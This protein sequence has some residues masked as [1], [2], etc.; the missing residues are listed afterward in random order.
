MNI[1][2]ISPESDYRTTALEGQVDIDPLD[3]TQLKKAVPQV[4]AVL[5]HNLEIGGMIKVANLK[6]KGRLDDLSLDGRIE[7]TQGDVR[8]GNSFHKPARIPLTLESAVRY[9]GDKIVIQKAALKLHTLVLHSKGEIGLGNS[10]AI[11]LSLDSEPASLEG[12]DK[13]IPA[14]ADRHTKGKLNL[15]ATLRGPVGSGK[16]PEVHGK[17]SFQNAG[18]QVS[19]LPKPIENLNGV[20]NLS[21]QRAE[22]QE[23]NFH[24]GSSRIQLA[25]SV[26]RL[27]PL[28]LSYRLNSQQLAVA[29][30]QRS[31]PEHRSADVLRNLNSDGQLTIVKGQTTVT[32]K[33]GSSDGR[34][35]GLDYKNLDANLAYANNA[36]ALRDLRFNA[37]S[38]SLRLTGAYSSAEIPKF[39]AASEIKAVDLGQLS[40]YFNQEQSDVR[41]KLNGNLKLSGAGDEWQNIK[42]TL[43]GDGRGE[44][45]QG[46][47]LNFNLADAVLSGTS[48]IP[49]LTNLINPAVRRKYPETFE[50]KDT[51]FKDLQTQFDVGDSRINFKNLIIAAAQFKVEGNGWADF[52]RRVDFRAVVRFSPE[53]SSDIA[54]SVR[55]IRFLFNRNNELEIPFTLAGQMP[56]VRPQPDARFLTKSLQRGLV[57][58]GVDELQQQLFGTKERNSADGRQKDEHR[59]PQSSPEDL[60]RRGLEGLFGR[61]KRQ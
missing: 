46:V 9:S 41:G 43:T 18:I 42:N 11:N 47:L 61:Q 52:N 51:V 10:P 40:R 53:L 58:G 27:S 35:Y 59:L 7:G 21:G 50:A 30:I 38:G 4:A 24:L 5:P 39:T 3:L 8:Y 20:V 31:L 19:D 48:G 23:T 56:N 44:V 28:S 54:G 17:L 14:V 15:H 12:W 6:V 37:F 25:A 36:L 1:G 22:I 55:Q 60:I 49:G 2:P 26:D 16:S 33:I 34:L 57:Q 29:D 32:G 13:L 45:L